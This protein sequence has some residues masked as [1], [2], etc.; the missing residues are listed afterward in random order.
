MRL[1]CVEDDRV[2]ALLLEQS[3]VAAGV[4]VI[5]WAE[6]GAEALSLAPAFG[7]QLLVLD[8]HLPDTDG[9]ALLAALRACLQAPAL[10]AVLYTAEAPQ[11]VL[12]PATAAGFLGVWPKPVPP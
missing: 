8:L 4:T 7:P 10:P 6:T 1:L 9:L 5:E 11:D 3:C 2:N 12:G